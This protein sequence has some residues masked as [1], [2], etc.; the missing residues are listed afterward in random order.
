VKCR[1]AVTNERKKKI[2]VVLNPQVRDHFYAEWAAGSHHGGGRYQPSDANRECRSQV[3]SKFGHEI[4]F[5]LLWI[6]V[7]VKERAVGNLKVDVLG[8]W[9][10][11]RSIDYVVFVTTHFFRG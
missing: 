6:Y 4:C 5:K 11:E 8:I 10:S 3:T 9:E 2:D 1:K 7:N